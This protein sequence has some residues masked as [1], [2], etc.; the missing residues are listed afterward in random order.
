MQHLLHGKCWQ[1]ASPPLFADKV[2]GT[3]RTSWPTLRIWRVAE[4][5]WGTS[6]LSRWT[7]GRVDGQVLPPPSRDRRSLP[8]A[9]SYVSV[10]K[11]HLQ[12]WP[13][14][15]PRMCDATWYQEWPAH[16]KRVSPLAPQLHLSLTRHSTR[17][18]FARPFQHDRYMR[19]VQ[20]YVRAHMEWCPV[21]MGVGRLSGPLVHAVAEAT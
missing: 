18:P 10:L 19:A 11:R 4:W 13:P 5:F 15:P 21:G 2:C 8:F 14:H 1:T 12:R 20:E 3:Q 9:A 17:V 6:S 16:P 7:G